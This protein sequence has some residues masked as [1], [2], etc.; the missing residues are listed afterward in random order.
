MIR[1]L[2]EYYMKYHP[3]LRCDTGK[4][5]EI[6]KMMYQKYNCIERLGKHPWVSNEDFLLN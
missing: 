3:E 6:G 1:E 5:Q 2:A 4:F